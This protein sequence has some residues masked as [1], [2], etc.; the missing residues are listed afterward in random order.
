MRTRDIPEHGELVDLR[1]TS[2]VGERVALSAL[3][4][5]TTN[6]T[7]ESDGRALRRPGFGCRLL[8]ESDAYTRML[9][10]LR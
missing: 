3:V 6:E 9:D 4:W 10:R 2:P 8:D 7:E 5:W 1:F